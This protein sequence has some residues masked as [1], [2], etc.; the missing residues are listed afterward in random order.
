MAIRRIRIDEGPLLRELRLRALDDAPDA[1]GQRVP[2]AMAIS[3][4]EWRAT[5]RVSSHG[6]GRAWFLADGPDGVVGMVQGRRRPVDTLLVF[7]MW[8]DPAA[9]R[10]GLG[11]GLIEAAE[12]WARTWN[13]RRTLLWVLDGNE[14]AR[15][16]YERLGFSVVLHGPDAE[17]GA[18][19]ASFPMTR[20]IVIDA[21]G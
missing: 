11:R 7:S 1:F 20:A 5:A 10:L 2:D 21:E 6:T 13:G 17:L 14:P 18:R 8:V 3:E 19:H 4:S 15:R 12:S 9:R 16:F